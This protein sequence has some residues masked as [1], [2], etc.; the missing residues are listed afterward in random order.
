MPENASCHALISVANAANR[1]WLDV[2]LHHRKKASIGKRLIS[3]AIPSLSLRTLSIVI[4]GSK[5]PP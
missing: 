3:A 2:F 1:R 5:L 4:G